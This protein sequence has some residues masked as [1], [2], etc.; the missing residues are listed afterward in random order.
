MG[1]RQDKKD[2]KPKTAAAA[3]SFIHM[4]HNIRGGRIQRNISEKWHAFIKEMAE[5]SASRRRALS[6]KFVVT[7]DVSVSDEGMVTLKAHAVGKPPPPKNEEAIMYLDGDGHLHTQDP[8]Q[9]ELGGLEA[10]AGG[11]EGDDLDL[12]VDSDVGEDVG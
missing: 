8:N 2:D 1:K 6:G 3:R 10:I 7:F 12:D 5:E 11:A 9:L 4:L